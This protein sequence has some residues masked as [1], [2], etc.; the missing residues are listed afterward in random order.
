MEAEEIRAMTLEK[1]REKEGELRETVARLSM[2][3]YA[4]RLDKSHELG[5][6]K[7]DLARVL[8]IIGE[9][10]RAGAEGGAHGAA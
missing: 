5:A 7:K 1:L 4:N 3:R 2:K 10:Q 8:T 9:K 6:A